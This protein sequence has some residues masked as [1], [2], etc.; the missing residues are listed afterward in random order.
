MEMKHVLICALAAVSACAWADA[1]RD[2]KRPYEMVWAHREADDV[3]PLVR[4]E[5]AD[6]W[7][8]QTSNAA[9]RFET[10]TDRALFGDSVC[11]LYYRAT[12]RGPRVTLRLKTPQKVSSAFDTISCWVYG[13]NVYYMRTKTP[14][15]TVFAD[16]LDADGKPFSVN[17]VHVHHLEW[18]LA[19][20]RLNP[21]EQ[22]RAAKGATFLG[23]TL[24][25]GTNTE[26]RSLDFTSFCAFKEELKPLAFKPRAK[27]PNRVFPDAPAGLNTG[28]GELPFPNTPRTI[29]PNTTA[30]ADLELRAPSKAGAWDDLAFRWKGGAWQQV[31]RGGGVW[32]ALADRKAPTRFDAAATTVV[33]N[34]VTPLDV[35]LT[36][37][38]PSGGTVTTHVHQDGRSLVLDVATDRLD[39]HSV[40]FGAW[41]GPVNP[42]RVVMPYYTYGFGS[43]DKRPGVVVTEL[44]GRPFFHMAHSDWTQSNASQPYST[45]LTWD[46]GIASNGGTY[47]YA[48][49][50][51]VKNVC[52]ERFVYVFSDRVEDVLPNIPNAKSPWKHVTGTGVWRAH[53]ASPSRQKDIDTWRGVRARG[54]K[55]LIITD[56]EV[57]WRDGNESFT[58]RTEPAPKKGGNK[59]QYD[60]ARVMIDELGFV[61]GPY[62][63]FTDF[64]PVNGHWSADRVSRTASGELQ[65]A[66]NRCYAPKPAFAVEACERLTPIIQKKFHFNTAY[67]D[68]HTAVTPWG[69]CDYD[70]RV[71]GAGAF[72][73]TF[74]AFG[75]IMLIQKANWQG[76]VY[77]EG[78]NHFMYC[79]LTD[80]NY[81][82]DQSYRP[83]DNPWFVD[84]DL[85]RLHPL[86]CNF[87][88]GYETMFYPGTTAPKDPDVKA[89]RFLA[90]TVAFGH[91][92]F[93]LHGRVYEDRSYFMIQALAAKYCLSDVEK[94]RYVG[95]DG[96]AVDTSTAL[97]TGVLQLSQ[98]AVWY[99]DGTFVAANGSKSAPMR[100][101]GVK[102][103]WLPPNGYCGWSADGKVF[104]FSGLVDGRRVDYS[105]SP[106]Y[107]YLDGRGTETK[108]PDGSVAKGVVIRLA[109]QG[110]ANWPQPKIAD[111]AA[112]SKPSAELLARLQPPPEGDF[113]LPYLC[114]AGCTMRGQ[115]GAPVDPATGAFAGTSL[116]T[117][118]GVDKLGLSMHPPWKTPARGDVFMRYPV[119]LPSSP[120]VFSAVV[121]KRDG[122][123]AG[124]GILYR[125]VLTDAQGKMHE[126]ARQTVTAHEWVPISADLS[127]W[128]GQHVSLLLIADPGPANNTN[129]DWA[130]WAD[131]RLRMKK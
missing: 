35:T 95:L 21:S 3:P 122:S 44:A 41:Q 61:Y 12:G 116:V 57:G 29:I 98:V 88:M 118:G 51:G 85:L 30:T 72:T 32:F 78:N 14:S 130:A 27:R 66:W 48:K 114:Q 56:H 99:Q 8:V 74:Y 54:I 60:Y 113:P 126:L 84:F 65:T 9:A 121:G 107:V 90:A 106:E 26:D 6:E 33:T 117:C 101:P 39:V 103:L 25:G 11:R 43:N 16:F 53:G 15:T 87:G 7:T 37:T 100:V 23:F 102:D 115:T 125:L 18:Y 73:S 94:I 47:Y 96:K 46:G 109:E 31:A 22:A 40:R 108:F 111:F 52:R 91:P 20:R 104:V 28:V 63:N 55:H 69:R 79:G 92:G 110:T 2:A 50:D 131:M 127:S 34:R 77:S 81:A 4:L 13:N 17:L 124:D 71:P 68:V 36:D 58:F 86:C 70:A 76:P 93:F 112:R 120:L 62:N 89:D 123:D 83:A 38:L 45:A 42:Q 80:G 119:T 10:A 105:V 97:A 59:G 49:T 67:C 129:G 64:A 75:E 19:R 82:Q 128:K 5:T 1:A 24:T